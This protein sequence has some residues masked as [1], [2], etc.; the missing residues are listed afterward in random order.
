VAQVS[1][2]VYAFDGARWTLQ[3]TF[4]STQHDRAL[5]F[6]Q[7]LYGHAHVKGVR[8]IQETFDDKSGESKQK[9]LLTRTKSEAVPKNLNKE[10]TQPKQM[11]PPGRAAPAAKKHR[12][13]PSRPVPGM[14]PSSRRSAPGQPAAGGAPATATWVRSHRTTGLAAASGAMAIG[15]G[16]IALQMTSQEP[17]LISLHAVF[18]PHYM[19][20]IA[21]LL[22]GTGM[23]GMG[24]IAFDAASQGGLLPGALYVDAGPAPA[25]Q[26]KPQL[27]PQPP[28]KLPVFP[29]I[30]IEE[31]SEPPKPATAAGDLPPEAT[32]LLALFH[33]ALV[34]L[35]RDGIY[36]KDGKLDTFNWF[37]C[38]LFFA[39]LCGAGAKLSKWPQPVA[40][41][42]ITTALGA[43]GVDPKT[44]ARFATRYDDY[45]TDS[46][47]LGIFG[48]G[49][50]VARQA[51]GGDG[52]AVGQALREAL[53]AWNA[54]IEP[55]P[56]T[57][58]VCV[59]FTD[60]VGSTEFTQTHGDAKQFE[61]VQAH[62]RIVR[63]A[64]QEF[65]GREIKHT[66]DGI[67]AAFDDASLAVRAALRIQSEI[68]AHRAVSPDIG[69]AL[70]IGLA[71]G[72][73]IKSGD[74]LFG[75]TVQLAARV[76]AVAAGDQTVITDSVREISEAIGAEFADLGERPLKGFKTPVRVHA[77]L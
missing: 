4:T 35:P 66:G 24:F 52:A 32:R 40:Q 19:L 59:M 74:D 23:A 75:S 51:A 5:E 39:G 53:A 71:A 16:L 62:N 30:E 6:G 70:R 50:E 57:G 13:V 46:R 21:V 26:L 33:D 60:I 55:P 7:E 29:K 45:L 47:H 1:F 48:R 68:K 31:D 18:G 73:P 3:Q 64:L 25:P 36:M 43:S 42:V 76:C 58:H 41:R 67:M 61:M 10:I 72:E 2:E 20:V 56:P 34:A 15:A 9:S 37:G 38:H 12:P 22:V 44:A 11:E 49:A 8:V 65:S 54:K 14:P 69:M 28:A 17:L 27:K 77:V 63:A